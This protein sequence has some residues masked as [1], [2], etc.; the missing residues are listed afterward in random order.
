MIPI[1]GT[2][3]P[4]VSF[5]C[6]AKSEILVELRLTVRREIE[7]QRVTRE[8]RRYLGAKLTENNLV[9]PTAMAVQDEDEGF[10]PI[11]FLE[12][13]SH[14]PRSIANFRGLGHFG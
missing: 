12:G 2:V 1:E 7:S 10:A 3:A 6:L 14:P 11:E 8:G 13:I 9:L 4:P 5:S